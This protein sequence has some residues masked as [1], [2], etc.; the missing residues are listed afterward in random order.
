MDPPK[1]QARQKT[2]SHLQAPLREDPLP[3]WSASL[4]SVGLAACCQETS[5][6]HH[7]VGLS[8][9]SSWLSPQLPPGRRLRERAKVKCFAGIVSLT[10]L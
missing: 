10:R 7:N 5:A 2:S 4:C 8:I 1:G 3:S 6:P 9:L